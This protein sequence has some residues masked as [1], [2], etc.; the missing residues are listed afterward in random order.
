MGTYVCFDRHIH[1]GYETRTNGILSQLGYVDI[2]ELSLRRI[3]KYNTKGCVK[4]M[5]ELSWYILLYL[6]WLFFFPYLSKVMDGM[7][8]I[9]NDPEIFILETA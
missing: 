4:V 3:K 7:Y 9:V 2:N 6:E 8:N 1:I 5:P